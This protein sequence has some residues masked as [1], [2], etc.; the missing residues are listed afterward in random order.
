MHE[1]SRF[2]AEFCYTLENYKEFLKINQ[3]AHFRNTFLYLLVCLC[4]VFLMV[5]LQFGTSALTL[6]LL[7]FFWLG[8]LMFR[9]F[10]DRDGGLDYKRLIHNFGDQVPAQRVYVG[11]FGIRTVNES[12]GKEV[13]DTFDSIRYCM[14]SK[15]LLILV[16][17]LKLC[18]IIDKHTLQGGSSEALL[19]YLRENCGKMKKKVRTGKFGRFVKIL[20]ICLNIL[21]ALLSAAVLLHIPEKLS[22]QFTNRSSYRE[23]AL[24]LEA[25][26]IH[27]TDQT[28][29]ELEEFDAQYARESGDYY[30]DNPYDSKV[31]D[32]LYWEGCGVFNEDYTQW[33]PSESGVYWFDMEAMFV[34]RMYTD[35]L[36]GIGAMAPELNIT[37][38]TE[39]HNKVNWEEGT[40]I[41]TFQFSMNGRIHEITATVQQDWLDLNV[42]YAL[43][44]ILREDTDP[45]NL[46]YNLD[47]Q[48][49]L[50][51]YGTEAQVRQLK[52]L[53][54][55]EFYECIQLNCD[56]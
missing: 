42:M 30:R 34:D 11:S 14:E 28:I 18:H 2:Q 52:K 55:L 10:R 48:G 22:G 25:C 36:S 12:N 6:L 15:N 31:Y 20:L 33:T 38:I 4:L 43:G 29:R 8:L 24:A 5:M 50:L 53:T 47:G 23:M 26:D 7:S 54:G 13:A 39:Y 56:H 19:S 49:I 37:D 45:Q 41:I 40:G 17:H 21:A 3:E 32:L 27:I 35:F 1:D 16:D 46:W 9:K 44:R 51:Y